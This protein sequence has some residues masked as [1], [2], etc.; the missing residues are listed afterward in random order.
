MQLERM[1][2]RY[3]RKLLTK[4]LTC[5]WENRKE[6]LEV[7]ADLTIRHE[8]NQ[9]KVPIDSSRLYFLSGRELLL[10]WLCRIST[11]RGQGPKGPKNFIGCSFY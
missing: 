11:G 5:F 4:G 1:K 3:Q 2:E 7:R 6:Q 10:R 8:V 9:L